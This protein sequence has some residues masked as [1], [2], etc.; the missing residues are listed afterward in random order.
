MEKPLIMSKWD[1]KIETQDAIGLPKAQHSL[2][3]SN[4]HWFIWEDN[5]LCSILLCLT[6]K[7]RVSSPWITEQKLCGHVHKQDQRILETFE[8]KKHIIDHNKHWFGKPLVNSG[9]G[10]LEQYITIQIGESKWKL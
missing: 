3:V 1:S 9:R 8:G 5:H 4:L 2:V 10:I 6:I 7:E